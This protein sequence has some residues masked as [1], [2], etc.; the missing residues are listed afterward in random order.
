MKKKIQGL[1]SKAQTAVIAASTLTMLAPFYAT[2]VYDNSVDVKS[3]LTSLL[4]VVFAFV[5]VGGA[6]NIVLGLRNVA[7][8]VSDESGQD[9]QKLAKGKG[10]IFSGLIMVGAVSAMGL[11]GITPDK[12][13]GGLNSN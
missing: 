5:A 4:N 11:L 7:S 13:L 1:K 8:A 6:I 9:Q 2:S 10:Q 3:A 12:L